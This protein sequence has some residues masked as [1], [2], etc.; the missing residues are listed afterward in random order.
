M[1]TSDN[2]PELVLH[3]PDSTRTGMTAAQRAF[4]LQNQ[5]P[6]RVLSDAWQWF[7][8]SQNILQWMW[9]L[10]RTNGD[11]WQIS[12][13]GAVFARFDKDRSDSCSTGIHHAEP[14]TYEG[15][16]RCMTIILSQSN[17]QWMWLFGLTN[18]DIWQISR[19]GAV[20]ARFDKDRSD[21]CSTGIHHAEP[22]TSEGLVRCMTM[23]WSQN[24]LQWMW[25]TCGGL[26]VTVVEYWSVYCTCPQ[27]MRST[28]Y[29]VL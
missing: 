13:V 6:L 5:E 3:L 12:R 29:Y 16:V 25:Y 23:I 8:R 20:F 1:G 27:Y 22:R 10:G 26:G 4:T 19:V 11:I 2:F 28:Y 9:L 21:S 18:G 7:D 14:R 24:I 17:L 15:L